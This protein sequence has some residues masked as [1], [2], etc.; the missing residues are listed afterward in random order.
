MEIRDKAVIVTGGARGIGRG[1]AEAFAREGAH[2][3]VADLG[4]LAARRAGTWD[5]KLASSDDLVRTVENIGSAG[6]DAVGI[7]VDVT[8]AD[9]C[10]R[11]VEAAKEAFGGVDVL[12]NNAGLVKLGPIVTYEEEDWDKLFAVNTKG[13]FLASRAAIPEL[14]SRGEGVIL[15]IASVAG[16]RGVGG[17][18][19]YCASKFAVIGLTQAMAQE[20]G[21]M[22]VRV[23]AIC[24][25]V[26]ATAMWTDH[27]TPA[28]SQMTGKTD[29]REAFQA[30]VQQNTPLGRE[31]TPADV[32]EAAL[33]LARADNVTGVALTVAGGMEMH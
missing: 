30:Y 11:M 9:S 22:N 31:Q 26:L 3:A 1:I 23:N 27:L 25:G 14:V 18:G 13:V 16:K 32:A 10:A 4:S 28:V 2:V 12:V 6:G 15:N 7:E 29:E 19:A 20:L 21:P 5:Y 33:Y 24:P 8:D 17:L